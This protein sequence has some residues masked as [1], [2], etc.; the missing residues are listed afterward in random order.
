MRKVLFRRVVVLEEI[1]L[2][3]DGSPWTFFLMA[4]V[5]L[6]K[7]AK[8]LRC[9]GALIDDLTA[10][11]GDSFDGTC[12]DSLGCSK[13]VTERCCGL[14]PT[15]R[16]AVA[17]VLRD[18]RCEGVMR[19]IIETGALFPGVLVARCVCVGKVVVD[20]NTTLLDRGFKT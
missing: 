18:P 9:E 7:G 5:L 15:V 12:C 13:K 6:D 20:C 17:L 10:R 8:T 16:D 14:G 3:L 19:G 11:E 4:L 1:N 2:D